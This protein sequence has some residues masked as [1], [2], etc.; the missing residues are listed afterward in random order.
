MA[1]SV[2]ANW[3]VRSLGSDNNS[4][5]FDPNATMT[6][7]LSSSNGTSSTP[8]VTASNYTFVS[9][10]IGYHLF[11]KSGTSWTPGWYLIT[12]ISSGSAVLNAASGQVVKLNRRRSSANG[13]GT[14]DSL[15]SGTWAI[16]YTQNNSNRLLIT[17]LLLNT[18]STCSSVANPFTPATIGNTIRITAG[19]NF[20]A[21][22][23]VINSLSGV[24]ATLDRVAGTSGATNGTAY[25]GGAMQ[26]PY[27]AFFDF[28]YLAGSTNFIYIKADGEYTWGT[29]T[30][31]AGNGYPNIFGYE[32]YRHDSGRPT[33]TFNQV[34]ARYFGRGDGNSTKIRNIIADSK[35]L[36]NCYVVYNGNNQ[37]YSTITNC[38][39]K[40]YVLNSASG[41]SYRLSAFDV[42]RGS[43]G[44]HDYGTLYNFIPNTTYYGGIYGGLIGINTFFKN[45]LLFLG[46][47]SATNG[48][49]QNTG[50]LG[51]GFVIKNNLFVNGRSG[52][53]GA[54]ENFNI[55][56]NHSPVYFYNNLIVNNAG[57]VFS[58]VGGYSGMSFVLENNYLFNCG[59]TGT[60][61][62]LSHNTS[63]SL[64]INNIVLS[65]S[66]FKDYQNYDFRM[67]DDVN[68]GRLVKFDT[69][70]LILSPSNTSKNKD[71]GPIQNSILPS[72][73]NMNGGMRG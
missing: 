62:S 55:F 38:I 64:N 51:G 13:I 28:N 61:T 34:G 15:S 33:L 57:T 54:Y 11:I 63:R 42:A 49:W 6:S 22:V 23:F 16:D 18:S 29:Q 4:G 3:E 66:P 69:L 52:V 47:T 26:N 68:G 44:S 50:Q 30:F 71:V 9:G 2:F 27:N 53:M 41:L 70:P 39:F 46:H 67:N 24:I 32:N 72:K 12:S 37:P 36:Y 35:D 45:C 19:T 73:I 31:L 59:A 43:I 25:M 10:D 17:D 40:N 60:T 65:A 7:T 5:C 14:T 8:T 48:T 58:Y 56:G 20:T 21:Q 1:S